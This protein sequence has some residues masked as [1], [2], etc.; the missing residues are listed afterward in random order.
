MQTKKLKLKYSKKLVSLQKIENSRG[1]HQ[2]MVSFAPQGGKRA[3]VNA[4]GEQT[5]QW[6]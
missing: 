1:E 4:N 5:Q 3:H 6:S 2:R